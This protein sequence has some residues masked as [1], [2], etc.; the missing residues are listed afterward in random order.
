M[1]KTAII[2]G[3]TGFVGRHMQNLLQEKEYTVIATGRENDIRKYKKVE[4]LVRLIKPHIV[5]NL[6]ALTTVKETF[7]SPINAYNTGFLGTYYLLKALKKNEFRGSFLNISSSEVYGFPSDEYLPITEETPLKPMSPYSVNKISTEMLCFQWSKTEPFKIISARP[8]THIGPGQSDRFAISNFAKQ[9]A[10][11]EIGIR[12][13]IVQ[14][15]NLHT[16][17]DITDVRDVVRAYNSLLD[18]GDSGDVYNICSGK[19]ISIKA[20]LES[21]IKF[22]KKNISIKQSELL[23]RRTEQARIIGSYEKIKLKT[24]WQPQIPIQKTLE[25]TYSYWL[26]Q[27]KI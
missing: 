6:A 20:I 18:H 26:G 11:I 1:T 24:N 19:E 22:T 25:D 4:E 10:E 7:K 3:G 12:S 8:F 27:V 9:I 2:I 16:T 17:R 14:V 21:L 15:G 5:I 13:P 23:T